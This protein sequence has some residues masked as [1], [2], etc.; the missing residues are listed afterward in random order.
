MN[1]ARFLRPAEVHFLDAACARL[2]PAD[3]LGPGAREAGVT[4]FIDRQLAGPWG[5]HA[6]NYRQG[7]WHDGTPEQGWQSRHS[8]AQMY[9]VAIE[10]ID[11]HCNAHHARPFAQLAPGVQDGVLQALERDA[12]D[13]PGVRAGAF[14]ALLWKN[15]QEGFFADPVH[16]GNVDKAGWRLVGFPGVAS[17][18]YALAMT[19]FD[20]RY[21]GASGV[22]PVS[23][24]DIES[25]RIAVDAQGQPQRGPRDGGAP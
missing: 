9:R 13:L 1:D 16:G 23:I 12:I 18:D 15:V 2:I 22:E 19:R 5:A 6:R 8:P 17:G 4:R 11:A 21:G 20:A 3:D 24:E 25:G 7:P 10:A 14:F